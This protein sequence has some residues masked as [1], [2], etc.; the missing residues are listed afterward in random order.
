MT[1]CNRGDEQIGDACRS[2]LA[3]ASQAFENVYGSS[4]VLS[5]HRELRERATLAQ[6]SDDVRV[7]LC[8]EQQLQIN[9]GAC[10]LLR[11]NRR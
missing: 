11:R 5:R 4:E 3:T 10:C 9:D 7:R 8:A 2:M 6:G 1:L